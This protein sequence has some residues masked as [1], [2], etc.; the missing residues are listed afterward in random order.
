MR[1]KIIL[2]TVF[3][4]I[5]SSNIIHA[6]NSS[7]PVNDSLLTLSKKFY[8]ESLFKEAVEVYK[9]SNFKKLTAEELF[10]LGLSYGNLRATI[11]ASQYFAR[12]V[13][14]TPDHNG[15]RLQLAR[16]LSQLGKTNEAVSNYNVIV[17]NDSNNVT[18]LYELALINFDKK[19]YGKAIQ[20]FS[21][22]EKLNENDF[23]S[24][25]YLGYA[26]LMSPDPNAAELITKHLEHSVAINPEYIPAISLLACFQ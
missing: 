21:K 1:K 11:K 25:Y 15:Y 4:I 6:Q 2:F 12:A 14:L 16:L 20:I 23:L 5:Q 8:N 18:A 9:D 19:E 24:S 10:Y 26:M 13:E 22:L 17:Q 7:R 3:I